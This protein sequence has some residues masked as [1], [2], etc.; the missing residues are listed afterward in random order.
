MNNQTTLDKA[1]CT[2][3]SLIIYVLIL[4]NSL[5]TDS[6]PLFHALLSGLRF[7]SWGL[8][9]MLFFRAP[10]RI[11]GMAIWLLVYGGVVAYS[12]IV[13]Q[14][15]SR[16]MI[17]SI[18]FDIL[19]LWGLCKLYL[20]A[21]GQHII[22]A[23]VIAMSFCVYLNSLLLIIYPDGIWF[24]DDTWYYILGGNYNQMGRTIIPAVTIAGYYRLRYNDLRINLFALYMCSFLTLLFVNSKTSILGMLI[25][26]AFYFIK[27]YRLRK[28]MG[29][30][31]ITVYLAFQT[32]VV[33]VQ[34][35]LSENEYISYFVEE[36]L[37]KDLTFTNRTDVWAKSL[38]LIQDSP[39]IGYGHQSEAWYTSQL[40]VTT[41]HNLILGQLITGGFVGLSIFILLVVIALRRYAK[42][43]FPAM[44]FLF[45]GLCT[46]FFMMI[47]EVYPFTYIA[48]LLI[49]LYNTEQ[50][51]PNDKLS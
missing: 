30:I 43:P 13:H 4:R 16:F 39:I 50:F 45:F 9:L 33:F 41:A 25:L 37:H 14:S 44:Q 51:A 28:W 20:P 18:G 48:L 34:Q 11:D 26:L 40:D 15:E 12:T 2:I 3:I 29:L 32:V 8:F 46:F 42:A 22:R 17:I 49:I 31:F 5:Y 19:M 35:D 7:I 47:M 23:I 6:S 1:T 10:K 21:Y 27:S 38:I 24:V 36:V